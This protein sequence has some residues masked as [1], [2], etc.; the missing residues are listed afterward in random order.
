MCKKME[1][2]TN[3]ILFE[4]F[5]HLTDIYDVNRISR[6]CKRWNGMFWRCVGLFAESVK[7]MRAP[8]P[9]REIC[10]GCDA[11]GVVTSV[12]IE[13]DHVFDA[14]FPDKVYMAKTS[15]LFGQ[16]GGRHLDMYVTLRIENIVTVEIAISDE[17]DYF[18]FNNRRSESGTITRDYLRKFT[19]DETIVSC[20]DGNEIIY[21][22]D[23]VRYHTNPQNHVFA[24]ADMSIF[25]LA[26]DIMVVLNNDMIVSFKLDKG[27]LDVYDQSGE[28]ARL[29]SNEYKTIRKYF[30]TYVLV[31][32][33]WELRGLGL[34]TDQFVLREDSKFF[35]RMDSNRFTQ[36]F[37]K[38]S[39][40]Q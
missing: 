21:I 9:I 4:I 30:I 2:I 14:Q 11:Q 15:G 19:C 16:G 3:D 1:I 20:Y 29:K 6:T 13:P 40:M 24:I 23:D 38:L 36:L 7:V 12:I 37:G 10:F 8:E 28:H 31:F 17:S 39:K 32:V 34:P 25:E 33:I 26:R 18:D 35:D 22:V 27:Y 5:G